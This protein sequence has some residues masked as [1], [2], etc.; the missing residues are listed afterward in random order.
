MRVLLNTEATLREKDSGLDFA[1]AFPKPINSGLSLSFKSQLQVKSLRRYV[2]HGRSILNEISMDLNRCQAYLGDR[3]ILASIAK[4][5]G[6]FCMDADSWGFDSLY[7]TA[8]RLQALILKSG[9]G[10][11]SDEIWNTVKRNLA[12]LFFL[13]DQ[14]E[15]DFHRRLLL[16][17]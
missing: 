16:S 15:P 6:L 11:W 14:C 10:A 7:N 9:S 1:D 2:D 8:F 4:R 13:L 3:S 12:V 5:L 17:E